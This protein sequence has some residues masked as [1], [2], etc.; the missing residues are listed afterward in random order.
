MNRRWMS[1]QRATTRWVSSLCLVVASLVVASLVVS[2]SGTQPVR[3]DSSSTVVGPGR[4]LAGKLSVGM[5]STCAVVSGGSARCWGAN[6]VGQLGRDGTTTVGDDE[7]PSSVPPLDFGPGRTAR[8]ISAGKVHSCA[9]LDD[10]TVR[11]WGYNLGGLLGL[12]RVSPRETPLSAGPV[13]L[14]AGRTA[15][16][17]DVGEGHSCAILDTGAVR[18]WGYNGNG[19]LGLPLGNSVTIGDDEV[20]GAAATVDLGVGR[21]ATA[22]AAGAFHTCAI[23]DTG[24]VRCWG[25]NGDGQLGYGNTLQIGDNESPA[26]AGP[27][28]LGAGRTATAITVGFAFSCA[29][30]DSGRVRCWGSNFFG[31]LGIAS[32][33]DIGDD[34]SLATAPLV[35]LKPPPLVLTQARSEAFGSALPEPKVVSIAAGDGHVCAITSNGT[36]Y[37]WGRG[38]LGRTG[39]GNTLVLGDDEIPGSAAV[40]S[41]GGRAA[42]AVA[43]GPSNTCVVLDDGH[44]RCWGAGA[45]GQVGLG[46]AVTIGDD[47]SPLSVAVIDL[48]GLVTVPPGFAS[49]PSATATPDGATV[50]WVLA[51]SL[52]AVTKVVVTS[53]SGRRLEATLP[54]NTVTFTGLPLGAPVSFTVELEAA[55][56]GV[57]ASTAVVVP[58]S[59]RFVPLPPERILDTRIGVGAPVGLVP[60]G[61]TMALSV[62]GHGGVPTD[63]VAAVVLNVTATE[64]TGP[65]YVTAFPAG[66]TRPEASNLNIERAGQ[67]IPNLV[68]V[69]VGVG[70]VVDLFSLG[71]T[72]LIAD[73]AGYFTPASGLESAGRFTAVDPTRVL[74]TRSDAAGSVGT[75]VARELE[76]AAH[77]GVPAT[78]AAAVVMNVTVTEATGPGFLTA[79]P[80][81]GARPE[82]SNLNYVAGQTI[83][84]QVIVPLGTG[85]RV[86]LFAS[87][88][89][90]VVVDVAGWFTDASGGLSTDGLFVPVTPVR[91]LDSRTTG[92]VGAGSTATVPVAE[93]LGVPAANVGAAALNVTATEATAAGFVTAYPGG[94]ARPTASN[95]NVERTGQTIPDH[96]VVRVGADGTIALFSQSGGHLIADIAGWFVVLGR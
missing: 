11:C 78:G 9:I 21:T 3:A 70:G 25:F 84:N 67:T 19:Q 93:R 24:A 17:L 37:C 23:L 50:S 39:H 59:T 47:E 58:G 64:T 49:P 69:A 33:S 34:E 55:A 91:A 51:P 32:T 73:V 45:G 86:S 61:A 41:L 83:A 43:V 87:A 79:F 27:V 57:T 35:S 96:A 12:G 62:L 92:K 38:E 75:G 28:D 4:T 90:H 18:C 1:A 52:P 85:G 8:A 36:L 26:A 88:G 82:A 65:G 81:G 56:Q 68:T 14:G 76:I 46:N 74:D 48:G 40:V 71:G 13:D 63:G 15:V 53:S 16:A 2:V 10:A 94:S 20:P 89:T 5:S 60:A 22:I 31:Q 54:T 66:V 77:G 95:V 72:H 80:T 29:L 44:V 42:T 7:T 6:N 30:L